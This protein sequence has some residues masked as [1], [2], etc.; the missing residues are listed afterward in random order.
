MGK[1]KIPPSDKGYKYSVLP[2]HPGV[3]CN[4]IGIHPSQQ[5]RKPTSS[6]LEDEWKILCKHSTWRFFQNTVGPVDTILADPGMLRSNETTLTRIEHKYSEWGTLRLW[7]QEREWKKLAKIGTCSFLS[8]ACPP[9]AIPL[10]FKVKQ[11]ASKIEIAPS[12]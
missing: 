9:I 1:H 12:K 11:R 6:L 7:V 8:I 4:Q 10:L 5:S 3:D 2:P